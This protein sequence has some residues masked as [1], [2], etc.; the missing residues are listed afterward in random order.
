MW[1][2]TSREA[3]G[4]LLALQFEISKGEALDIEKEIYREIE[5]FE[6]RYSRFRTGNTLEKLNSRIGEWQTIDE[7]TFS[8][9][10]RL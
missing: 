8:L 10:S 5:L 4:S 3:L 9:L 7:E 1:H 2:T 6:D